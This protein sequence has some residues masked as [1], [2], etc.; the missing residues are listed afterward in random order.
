M[1]LSGQTFSAGYADGMF[2]W[3][4]GKKLSGGYWECTMQSEDWG[5]VVQ[6]FH[7]QFISATRAQEF[8]R[9]NQD[10]DMMRWV[11]A[12]QLG[13]IV[14]YHNGFGEF[15]RC[16]VVAAEFDPERDVWKERGLRQLALVGNWQQP[17]VTRREDG[18]V[19]YPYAVKRLGKIFRP[20]VSNIWEYPHAP[21]RD[22]QNPAE[23]EPL[24]VEPP[25]I[26][27]EQERRRILQ[28]AADEVRIELE[29]EV[30]TPQLLRELGRTLVQAAEQ[31]LSY[32]MTQTSTKRRCE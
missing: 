2:T 5:T 4:V 18:S 29:T 7:E 27:E 13:A 6:A 10:C 14:H 21:C 12:L 26:T 23:L 20:H 1:V 17:L 16:E 32:E 28:E 22:Y 11:D 25:P 9:I 8:Q 3:T 19:H 30:L 15:V 31:Y 24:S